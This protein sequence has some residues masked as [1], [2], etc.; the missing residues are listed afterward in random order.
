MENFPLINTVGPVKRRII[1]M[2]IFQRQF[3]GKSEIK[4][5]EIEEYSAGGALTGQELFPLIF[6]AIL[7]GIGSGFLSGIGTDIWKSLKKRIV[8]R[9]MEIE[10]KTGFSFSPSGRKVSSVFFPTRISNTTIIYYVHTKKGKV[11][12]DFDNELLKEAESEIAF[13]S[14]KNKITGCYL[15]INLN[16]LSKGGYLWPF[17]E[18]PSG[19][20]KDQYSL[21]ADMEKS[22]QEGIMFRIHLQVAIWFKELDRFNLA[23]KHCEIAAKIAPRELAPCILLTQLYDS[24][25][26]TDK[27]LEELEKASRIDE[28]NPD[29]HYLMASIYAWKKDLTNTI[30]ELEKAVELGFNDVNMAVNETNFKPFLGNTKMQMIIERIR[31]NSNTEGDLDIF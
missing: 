27:A 7:S 20:N 4:R 5:I 16:N 19:M 25:G 31:F 14:Q 23:I 18:I 10:N 1:T 30:T 22:A 17:S 28:K 13:L 11:K 24:T 9:V 26:N 6:V 12:L 3:F 21:L 29:I 15:G 8:K 2:S